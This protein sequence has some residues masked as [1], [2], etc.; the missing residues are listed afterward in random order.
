MLGMC[1]GKG[2]MDVDVDVVRAVM[3]GLVQGGVG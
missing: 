1:W 2:E 3:E